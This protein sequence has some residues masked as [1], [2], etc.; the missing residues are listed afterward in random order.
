MDIY[1]WYIGLKVYIYI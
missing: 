1:I